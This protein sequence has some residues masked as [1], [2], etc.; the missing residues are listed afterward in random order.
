MRYTRFKIITTK[1][2]DGILEDPE[3]ISSLLNELKNKEITCSMQIASGVLH[4]FVRIINVDE[5][6]ID[7]RLIQK[8]ATLTKSSLIS[9]ITAIEVDTSDELL[10]S[11]KPKPTRWS[12]LDIS[13]T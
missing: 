1:I 10:V 9:D 8:G 11:V 6:K 7:W 4:N 13:D 3:E 5:N 12:A 2:F